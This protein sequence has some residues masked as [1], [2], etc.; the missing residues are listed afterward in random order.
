MVD[1]IKK[2]IVVDKRNWSIHDI[3]GMTINDINKLA[4]TALKETAKAYKI[5]MKDL[6]VKFFGDQYYDEMDFGLVI[7]RLETDEELAKR[8]EK[9]LA[10]EKSK[11]ERAKKRLMTKQQKEEAK[12]VKIEAQEKELL[13]TLKKKYEKV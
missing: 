7:S 6:T 8:K 10:N 13:A 9:Y 12:L 5:A 1:F 11:I 3:D 4:K 2:V